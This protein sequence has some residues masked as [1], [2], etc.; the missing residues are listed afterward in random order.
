MCES[1]GPSNNQTVISLPEPPFSIPHHLN[2]PREVIYSRGPVLVQVFGLASESAYNK[3][4]VLSCGLGEPLLLA[5]YGVT[6]KTHT[7]TDPP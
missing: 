2:P 5:D 1:W 7:N 3:E 4:L 6:P